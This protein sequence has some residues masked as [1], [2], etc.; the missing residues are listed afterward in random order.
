MLPGV[1]LKNTVL[2]NDFMVIINKDRMAGNLMQP[3]R[4]IM[5]VWEWIGDRI[6]IAI[7]DPAGTLSKHVR[8]QTSIEASRRSANCGDCRS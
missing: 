7:S 4:C 8:D 3:G 1:F 2:Y 6:G 5:K